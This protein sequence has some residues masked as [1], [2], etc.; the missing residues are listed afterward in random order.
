[1]LIMYLNKFTLLILFVELFQCSFQTDNFR[2]SSSIKINR[3][4]ENQ[5]FHRYLTTNVLIL[6]YKND[7]V[8]P[9]HA[10]VFNNECSLLLIE[11]FES[12]VYV[13]SYELKSK[14]YDKFYSFILSNKVNTE[15][16]EYKSQSFKLYLYVNR[17]VI[18]CYPSNIKNFKQMFFERQSPLNLSKEISPNDLNYFCTIFIRLPIHVR[19]HEPVL[20]GDYANFTLR[21]PSLYASRCTNYIKKYSETYK[22][23]NFDIDM[24]INSKNLKTNLVFPCKKG[25]KEKDLHTLVIQ[26]TNDYLTKTF[27]KKNQRDVDYESINASNLCIWE[28][29]AFE[30]CNKETNIKINIPVGDTNHELLVLV[31]T[32]MVVTFLALRLS[33]CMLAYANTHNK[34]QK[35]EEN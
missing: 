31:I 23:E 5:G 8:N 18:K 29:L 25:V 26:N 1:M 13:D 35:L 3:R 24:L 4:I 22:L 6:G 32:V 21:P 28:S 2:D 16:A 15:S 7:H 34:N 19:Y 9:L 17:N 10:N 11:S 20:N 12:N 33:K 27:L 30:S 14:N